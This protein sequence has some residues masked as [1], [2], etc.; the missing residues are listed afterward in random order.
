MAQAW[1]SVEEA[2]VT[3]GISVR[4]L[5]RR[6]SRGEVLTR[7]ENNR[8][9]V[10]V[11]APEP[12]PVDLEPETEDY[13][14]AETVTVSQSS[15]ASDD[16]RSTML[17]LHEDRLRR[18]D[19]AILAYQ[20]SVTTSASEAR[21]S[22]ITSRFAWCT[23]GSLI[24]ILFLLG[25]WSTHRLTAAEAEVIQVKTQLQSVSDEA[26]QKQE[27]LDRIRTEADVARLAAARAEGELKAR[28]EQLVAA[29][30]PASPATQPSLVRSLVNALSA[31]D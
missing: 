11:E 18:T 24:V 2:A 14:D 21:R 20:Q 8:R 1:Q 22:R 19:L 6:I 10:L 23:A 9:E 3:L 16:V 7:L 15:V 17:A 5:H 12:E 27:Q 25:V 30:A 13:V 31:A 4:T 29:P 26:R 28:A